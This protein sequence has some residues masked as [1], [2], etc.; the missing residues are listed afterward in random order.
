MGERGERGVGSFFCRHVCTEMF[1][2][3]LTGMFDSYSVLQIVLRKFDIAKME[4]VEGVGP[5]MYVTC[6][7]KST[8]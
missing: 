5:C 8:V 2:S 3:V 4:W 6:T 7:D 1:R